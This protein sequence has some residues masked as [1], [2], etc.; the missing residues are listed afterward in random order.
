MLAKSGRWEGLAT[1]R[2]LEKWGGGWKKKNYEKKNLMSGVIFNCRNVK[3]LNLFIV[4]KTL[5]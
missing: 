4:H 2:K 3:D 1:H 5:K